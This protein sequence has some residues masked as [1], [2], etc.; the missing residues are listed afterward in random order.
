[1]HL[2][3]IAE[4]RLTEAVVEPGSKTRTCTGYEDL[5]REELM[6]SPHEVSLND[7]VEV[8]ARTAEGHSNS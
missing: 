3:S 1:V 8:V 2:S 4:L 6:L 5:G 7:F